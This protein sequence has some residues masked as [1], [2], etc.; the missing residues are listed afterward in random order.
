MTKEGK[1]RLAASNEMKL[2]QK[3]GKHKKNLKNLERA[4][5]V[6]KP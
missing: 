5:E 6:S 3:T 4:R 2:K 1:E